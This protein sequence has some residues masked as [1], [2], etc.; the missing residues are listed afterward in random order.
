MDVIGLLGKKTIGRAILILELFP[1]I[2][3]ENA[4]TPHVV[5]IS[6][7]LWKCR[8]TNSN[9]LEYTFLNFG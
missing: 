5:N 3:F 7:R 9:M 4:R 1:R 2:M 6:I 8:F